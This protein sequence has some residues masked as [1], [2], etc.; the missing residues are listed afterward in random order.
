MNVYIGGLDVPMNTLQL[1]N[2]DTSN[3]CWIVTA[4]DD[5]IYEV[6]N[7]TFTLTLTLVNPSSPDIVLTDQTTAT[8]TV[9]DDE[10][11]IYFYIILKVLQTHYFCSGDGKLHNLSRRF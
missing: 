11:M 1:S 7:E 4:T 8:I 9:M 6:D 3:N 10:G 5:E 2:S